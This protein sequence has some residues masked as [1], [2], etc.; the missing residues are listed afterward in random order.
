MPPLPPSL[1]KPQQQIAGHHHD[2][3]HHHDE[4]EVSIRIDIDIDVSVSLDMDLDTHVDSDK[5]HHR[6]FNR[7]LPRPR[8]PVIISLKPKSTSGQPQS[9]DPHH[10]VTSKQ[11]PL[12]HR[13]L[14]AIRQVAP[15][16]TTPT[17]TVL[18]THPTHHA[19]LSASALIG[20]FLG[21]VSGL[22]LL[23]WG[24]S[25]L[26][27]RRRRRLLCQQAKKTST[28]D[29]QP[30]TYYRGPDGDIFIH[31]L[32]SSG[33]PSLSPTFTSASEAT[34]TA[35]AARLGR[36]GSRRC[37]SSHS[38]SRSRSRSH[39]RCRSR[40]RS[41]SRHRHGHCPKP[42]H[43]PG[44]G[45]HD[46]NH[47]HEHEHGHWHWHDH[48]GGHHDH[49]CLVPQDT[50]TDDQ[51]EIPPVP[52]IPA[53]PNKSSTPSKTKEDY[54]VTVTEIPITLGPD[55][56]PPPT[57]PRARVPSGTRI[58][59]FT[60]GDISPLQQNPFFHV[61]PDHHEQAIGTT[62]LTSCHGSG[63]DNVDKKE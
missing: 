7:S 51:F 11:K 44:H 55:S 32:K 36:S 4:E 16:P 18:T 31:S 63:P 13:T 3:D 28:S 15:P 52:E 8:N 40:S 39:S 54:T 26:A 25:F 56:A 41:H 43:C 46:H 47:S 12:P 61:R 22:V 58:P 53:I 33:R 38:H 49:H 1:V 9:G 21:S 48:H 35:A 45:H 59:H 34:L 42:P 17:R 5:P 20:I 30:T 37:R 14:K 24:L 23:L 57:V 19:T 2:H 62:A 6:E 50:T 60:P 27:A 10:S 29:T